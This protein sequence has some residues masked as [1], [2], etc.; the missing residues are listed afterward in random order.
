MAASTGRAASVGPWQSH[1]LDSSWRNS[2]P[3]CAP[4]QQPDDRHPC[5][6]HHSPWAAESHRWTPCWPRWPL[7]AGTMGQPWLLPPTG[8]PHAHPAR[9]TLG[10]GAGARP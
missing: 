9:P 7:W 3:G 2:I 10:A 1:H 8:Q 6:A 4:L 5:Y